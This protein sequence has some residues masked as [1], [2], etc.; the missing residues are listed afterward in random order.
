VRI[1]AGVRNEGA[2][3]GLWKLGERRQVVYAKSAL[4]VRERQQM[5]N[6]FL[7]QSRAAEGDDGRWNQ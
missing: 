5:A 4:S 3:D 1:C 2:D 7:A 6:K